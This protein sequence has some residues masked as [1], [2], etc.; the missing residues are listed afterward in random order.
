M[1]PKPKVLMLM[2][3]DAGGNVPE[4]TVS[5]SLFTAWL[6][7]Q[8]ATWLQSSY[9]EKCGIKVSAVLWATGLLTMDPVTVN[10]AGRF[11]RCPHFVRCLWFSICYQPAVVSEHIRISWCL[12]SVL[13][14]QSSSKLDCTFGEKLNRLDSHC[15]FLPRTTKSL[16]T[17]SSN[18][19]NDT[20]HFF[21][22]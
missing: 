8:A 5:L 17:Q 12:S 10:A 13:D 14:A 18:I 2:F 16:W 3:E 21:S 4:K 9:A 20:R 1:Q 6:T 7:Q 22:A 19:I 11:C 15:S